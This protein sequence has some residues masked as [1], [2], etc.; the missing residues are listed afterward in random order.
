MARK[1]IEISHADNTSTA[2][3]IAPHDHPPPSADARGSKRKPRAIVAP[4]G[5]VRP[6]TRRAACQPAVCTPV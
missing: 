3:M 4:R 6:S 5:Q 1:V 2:Q